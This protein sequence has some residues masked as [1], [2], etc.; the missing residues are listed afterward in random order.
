MPKPMGN[1]TSTIFSPCT[2]LFF[3]ILLLL[4]RS[5]F[6]SHLLLPAIH[7]NIINS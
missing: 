5:Y 3:R 7:V 2:Q 6:Y 1:L 4:L